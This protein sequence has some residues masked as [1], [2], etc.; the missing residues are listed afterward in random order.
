M[1]PM[2]RER[3]GGVSRWAALVGGCFALRVSAA[4][5]AQSIDPGGM[6]LS[7]D[8]GVVDG[9]ASTAP[10]TAPRVEVPG[11]ARA[12]SLAP[13]PAPASRAG[14]TATTSTSSPSALRFVSPAPELVPS[15]GAPEAPSVLESIV[16]TAERRQSNL[17]NTPI[18]ISAFSPGVLQERAIGSIRD[19]AGQVPNLSIARANISYTTQTYSLRGVGET[20]PIQEP[21]VA[22]Y[23]DDV[24]QPRQL[25]SMLDFNDVERVEVLRGPQ[26][27]LYGRNSSAGALRV[28]TV[29]P[30][31]DLRTESSV[32]AGTFRAVRALTSV[33]GPLLRDRLAASFSFLH[34]ARDGI[35][36]DPTLDRDVNRI[37][38]DSARAKL[39][40]TP[41]DRLDVLWTVTGTIDRSDSRSYVPATQPNVTGSCAPA[42]AWQCPGFATN[43]SYSEVNPYQHL[44]QAS[45]SLRAIYNISDALELKLIS[46]GGGFNLNPVYYDNDGVAALVQKNLIHYDDAYF[47]QEAQLNGKFQRLSFTSGAFYLR[48][49][50]F[51]NRDGYSRRNTMATDPAVDPQNY[52]FLRAHNITVT[53]SLAVFG[54]ANVELA[55]FVTLTGGL[56]ETLERKS[57][58]F[59][60]A[61]LDAGGG[62]VAPSI[63]GHASESWSALTPKVSLA[64]HWPPTALVYGTYSRGFKSG[65]FDNRATNL[66]LAERP[67]NPEFV[68]SYEVGIK[69]ELLEHRLRANAA[70]F[71]NDYRDLQVSYTDPAY[72]GNS[73]RGN[74]GKAHSAGVELEAGARLSSAFS[75][76]GSGGYL[77]AVYD[78][79]KNAGGMGVNAD[80]H[81]L[82][83]APR[84]NFSGGATYVV[85][86]DVPGTVRFAADVE[87]ASAAYS[88]ALARPQDQYPGQTFVNG[89]LSWTSPGERVVA[90]LAS[91]NLLDSQ[92]PVSASYTP[93]TGVLFYNFP[94]PRTVL[95]TLKYRL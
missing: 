9:S 29:D 84:W 36:F 34:S 13:A 76:Q 20:D 49:R 85:P 82:I 4:A 95:F 60:N 31:N 91:R 21:V 53:D 70:G 63:R 54:E 90:V 79:Y 56:R 59:H 42:A 44:D 69:S 66:M 92:K 68:N 57:F 86:V 22:I 30:G 28:I 8:A 27:T 64:F 11:P 77:Y 93:S 40:F 94:D 25:G 24:Y 47:T 17:Q 14:A 5:M 16:V 18:A 74:A 72:P 75:L 83:N 43:R 89:T 48:E 12:A 61:V 78:T 7:G 65:G 71:Y 33:R 3:H 52:A 39:R 81:P 73:I 19:L 32:S 26:G 6:P 51:V 38:V 1:N 37:A 80:G 45:S 15:S 2:T 35:T 41:T 67:F 62:F 46:A 58:G 55:S 50:F 88:S 87:Y 10:A 23:V